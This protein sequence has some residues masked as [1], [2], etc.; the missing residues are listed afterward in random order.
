MVGVI[1]W[2]FVWF[3][4]PDPVCG[5]GRF[6]K[7]PVCRS[8]CSSTKHPPLRLPSR[9]RVR[10]TGGKT[11]PGSG[12]QQ[13]PSF[14]GQISG[15]KARATFIRADSCPFVVQNHP[16]IS[17]TLAIP[18]F[19]CTAQ[20]MTAIEQNQNSARKKSCAWHVGIESTPL[21][22]H[23]GDLEPADLR[24]PLIAKVTAA[25]NLQYALQTDHRRR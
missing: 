21:R 4:R 5:F 16:C 24:R 6:W 2:I 12:S 14:R 19:C 18:P 22:R 9:L 11:P 7:W 3:F 20:P 10:R 13:A 8:P 15:W 17:R 1:C 23:S 25:K